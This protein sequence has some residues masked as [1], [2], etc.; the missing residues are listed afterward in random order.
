[1]K[2]T[3][4]QRYSYQVRKPFSAEFSCERE[5]ANAACLPVRP[6]VLRFSAPVARKSAEQAELPRA[7]RRAAQT[8]VRQGRQV[9]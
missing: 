7:E 1:V 3:I 8:R 5:R 4:E 2:T 6:M 9:R